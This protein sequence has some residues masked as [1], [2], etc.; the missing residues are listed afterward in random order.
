M[1]A[2]ARHGMLASHSFNSSGRRRLASD[3]NFE[4]SLN[5]LP[6]TPILAECVELVSYGVGL[7]VSNRL[8]NMSDIDFRI[9][10]HQNTTTASL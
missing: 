3:G 1:P 5:H 6:C 9:L 7:D 8:E 4:I 10:F 2:I